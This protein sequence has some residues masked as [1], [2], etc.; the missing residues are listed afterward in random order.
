MPDRYGDHD[1]TPCATCEPDPA[2]A[3]AG[4]DLCDVDGQRNGFP[5]DHTDWAAIAARHRDTIRRAA[6][7]RKDRT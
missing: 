7:P 6:T 4:C 3:V 5:C 2:Y 1:A